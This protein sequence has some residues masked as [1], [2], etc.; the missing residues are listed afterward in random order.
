MRKLTPLEK[1]LIIA[2]GATIFILA[3]LFG[4]SALLRQRNALK[5]E[6]IQLRG[7]EQD[8]AMWLSEKELWL[9][10][11]EWLD[12][13]QPKIGQAEVAQPQFFQDLQKSARAQ[14]L[15]IDEQG[16]GEISETPQYQAVTVR[17]RVSGSLEN[18]IKWLVTIQQPDQ[19]QAVTNFSLR[20]DKDP[21]KVNL[22]LEIAKW[23]APANG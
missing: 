20:S 12:A 17:M 9:K 21:P 5:L 15:A 6:S 4:V 19:F 8:A 1:K 11:K 2:L 14:N 13:R 3:N 10:R 16:F 23:H 22:E 18:V 7:E